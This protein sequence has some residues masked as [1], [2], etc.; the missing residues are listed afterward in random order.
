[1]DSFTEQ[2]NPILFPKTPASEQDAQAVLSKMKFR[3]HTQWFVVMIIAFVL[4]EFISYTLGL[5][6]LL[7][8]GGGAAVFGMIWA[9]A[10][11]KSFSPK[12]FSIWSEFREKPLDKMEGNNT[13][14]IPTQAEFD[15]L[16]PFEKFAYKHH[17][18]VFWSG[19][20]LALIII[21]WIW[22]A[23]NLNSALGL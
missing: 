21:G 15:A 16:T 2:Q 13:Q 4:I 8:T 9:R 6:Y 23:S 17:D 12:R 14:A 7:T 20:V 1:M 22:Y 10:Y 11:N 5:P 3:S 19:V 18:L